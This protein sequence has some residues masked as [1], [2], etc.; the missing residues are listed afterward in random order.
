MMWQKVWKSS[1]KQDI[2]GLVPS[3][4][5]LPNIGE[6]EVLIK[7]YSVES[8]ASARL[9]FIL[10]EKAVVCTGF[11]GEVYQKGAAVTAFEIGDFVIGLTKA[12]LTQ[13]HLAEFFVASVEFVLPM[14]GHLTV[15]QAAVLPVSGLAV[16]QLLQQMQISNKS[17]LVFGANVTIAHLLLE[18]G[19]HSAKRI[20]FAVPA[21]NTAQW[22][23]DGIS[24]DYLVANFQDTPYDCIVDFS[25][26]QD[27]VQLKKYLVDGGALW[28]TNQ[29]GWQWWTSFL[30][31][32]SS[33]KTKY[34]RLTINEIEFV[35]MAQKVQQWQLTPRIGSIVNADELDHPIGR[36]LAET[37][38]GALVLNFMV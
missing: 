37:E 38:T 1:Q 30:N 3:L 36:A 31:L 26:L 15:Q 19:K 7:V 17:V 27:A 35:E 20:S 4:E 22:V 9:D 32:F 14:P 2:S 12:L 10:D 16:Y 28:K 33:K 34:Y 23:K 13:T 29:P 6:K 18:M 25:D 21:E 11:C 24:K 5:H 8:R